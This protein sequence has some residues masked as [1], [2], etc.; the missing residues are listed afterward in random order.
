ME[1]ATWYVL[2]TST[3]GNTAFASHGPYTTRELAEA[4][5]TDLKA[6]HYRVEQSHT[7]LKPMSGWG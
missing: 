5:A 1:T 3:S 7:R 2:L 4:K 6:T